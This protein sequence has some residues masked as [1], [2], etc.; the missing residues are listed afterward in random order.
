MTSHVEAK[1]PVMFRN[2]TN[3][4]Q[5]QLED[6]S[7]RISD[8]L[9]IQM[10]ELHAR[11]KHDYLAALFGV[12]GANDGLPRAE[13]MLRSEM[14]PLL[15]EVDSKFEEFVPKRN[16]EAADEQIEGADMDIDNAASP[17]CEPEVD[18]ENRSV[19]PAANFDP[20]ATPEIKREP[21]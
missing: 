16:E 9:L 15:D 6:L 5:K 11:L 18:R 21:L 17:G 13:R 1:G 8:Q 20:E 19:T 10:Q 2:A 4:V 7:R 14:I 3:V 12:A